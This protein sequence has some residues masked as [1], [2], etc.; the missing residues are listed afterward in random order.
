MA[1]SGFSYKPKNKIQIA[2]EQTTAFNSLQVAQLTPSAQTDFVYGLNDKIVESIEYAGGYVSAS[3]GYGIACSSTSTS[4]SA[5]IQLR[6]GLKYAA[7]QGSLFR[8]TALFDTP[9][10]GNVQLIGVG[11][12]ECGYYFGYAGT[13]FGIYHQDT[14]AREI[15]RLDITTGVASTT[16]ITITLDGDSIVI[17]VAGGGLNTQTAYQ[18]S[19]ADYREVGDGWLVDVVS[20]SVYFLSARAGPYSGSFSASGTGLVASFTR[21]S[22]GISPASDFYPQSSWN[23]D[24]MDGTGPTRQV[25]DTTKGNVFEI[26]FQY[27]GQGNAYFGIEDSESGIIEPVHVIKNANNRTRPVLKNP[28]VSGLI[29]STNTGNNTNVIIKGASLGTFT[30]GQY[31]K[32]DPKFAHVRTFDSTDT[33]GVFRGIVALKV[34]RVYRDQAC[35]GEIDLLRIGG[36]NAAGSTTPKPFQIGIFTDS[37]IT[38]DV[39]FK[40]ID[41]QN[42]TISYADLGTV[43]GL[44]ITP[45]VT[46]IFSFGVN[47][48]GSN[49]IDLAELDYLFG[50]GRV[51]IIAYR[52]AAGV[53]GNS[54]SVNW[55]EQQ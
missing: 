24:K 2:K 39:N 43:T 37:Q 30:E 16:D 8:G 11:N 44:A 51:I 32:L 38:G 13:T 26:G 14:S 1:S 3:D 21:V 45:N 54:V 4:G 25:L 18:L 6:R 50:P 40:Y 17:P 48:G 28:K 5:A 9:V 31:K 33:S 7:G 36:T 15:R 27:L 20:G 23:Y 12:G 49:S 53:S 34:N 10:A 52:A 19:L 29:T 42:S 47:G 46:P 22:E 55:F 35:F 41:Q